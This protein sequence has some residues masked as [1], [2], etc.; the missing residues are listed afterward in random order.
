MKKAVIKLLP[1]LLLIGIASIWLPIDSKGF[2]W[3]VSIILMLLLL[4]WEDIPPRSS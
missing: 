2:G 4:F 3:F 1:P